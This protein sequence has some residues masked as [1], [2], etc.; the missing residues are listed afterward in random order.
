MEPTKQLRIRTTTHDVE[1]VREAAL[2][3]K[4][5][6]RRLVGDRLRRHLL[7][8]G[9]V[10]GPEAPLDSLPPAEARRRR[11]L[12]RRFKAQ[13]LAGGVLPTADVLVQAALVAELGARG[14]LDGPVPVVDREMV[15]VTR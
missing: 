13:A 8:E 11:A 4:R 7:A 6:L 15:P 12:R 10:P 3:E 9:T 1:T 14:W 5:R 2:A